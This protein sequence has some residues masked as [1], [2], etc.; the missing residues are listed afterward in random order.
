MG[1]YICRVCDGSR[2]SS[3]VNRLA[4]PCSLLCSSTI[5]RL[6][7]LSVTIWKVWHY[8]LTIGFFCFS[9]LVLFKFS[10]LYSLLF[11]KI[12]G[13]ISWL[14]TNWIYRG[15]RNLPVCTAILFLYNHVSQCIRRL[16]NLNLYCMWSFF[17]PRKLLR[18]CI[19][20]T[21]WNYL[22][23]LNLFFSWSISLTRITSIL[24]FI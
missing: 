13:Y 21:N 6:V 9:N 5:L 15:I 19:C 18:L 8:L 12:G 11:F 23:I 22:F 7:E 3:S 1:F 14:L 17:I 24:W 20:N 10:W 16:F 2:A 4:G